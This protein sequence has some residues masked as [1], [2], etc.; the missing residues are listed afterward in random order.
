VL[1]VTLGED[2]SR[3]RKDDGPENMTILRKVAL[4]A[5]RADTETK[6]GIIGRREQMAWSNEYLEHIYM[7]R[8][9]CFASIKQ[10]KSAKRT[11]K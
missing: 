4:T 11:R 1:D 8:T 2:G 10:E 7:G 9:C 3:P 5:A 6:S